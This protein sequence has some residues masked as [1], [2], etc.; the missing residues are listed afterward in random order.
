MA[1]ALG[2]EAG[3]GRS[4]GG[5]SGRKEGRKE[6]RREGRGLKEREEP[7]NTEEERRQSRLA[8]GRCFI[9]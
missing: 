8:A 5:G 4:G 9:L 6:G 1:S 2:A 3:E 7:V